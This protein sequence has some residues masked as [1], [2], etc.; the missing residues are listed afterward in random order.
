MLPAMLRGQAKSNK[1]LKERAE[2]YIQSVKE[3]YEKVEKDTLRVEVEQILRE[4]KPGWYPRL[5]ELM[6]SKEHKEVMQADK[7]LLV[8]KKVYRE[9]TVLSKMS[10]LKD[11]EEV[12][13][14]TVFCLRR[15]E[16]DM[17]V[18][19]WETLQE[20]MAEWGLSAKYLIAILAN[21]A[22]FRNLDTGYKLSHIMAANGYKDCA[23]KLVLWIKA[24]TTGK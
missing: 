7:G 5:A 2:A 22:I 20:L 12:Y 24:Q 17:L 9:E 4:K 8:L 18:E 21:G 14:R 19:G 16:L 3:L 15:I 10:S 1:E 23:E 11:V 13:Q 6:Q